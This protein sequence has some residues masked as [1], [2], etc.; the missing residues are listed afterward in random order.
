[1]ILSCSVAS[2]SNRFFRI[3]I[4]FW[5]LAAAAGALTCFAT[6]AGFC[7]PL[8][9]LFELT[10]HFRLQ[11]AVILGVLAV[12]FAV[13][14][15]ALMASLFAIGAA[16]NLFVIAPYLVSVNRM[17]P[18]ATDPLRILLLNV[19]TENSQY[20]RLLDFVRDETP[21]LV[22]LLEID[23][24]WLDALHP[25]RAEYPYSV[26]EPRDDNFGIALLSRMPFISAEMFYVGQIGV[27]SI[28]AHLF[29]HDP[30]E[31]SSNNQ[32][33]IAL[34]I[35]H[36][37]PPD[38]LEK[39][40]LRNH[41]LQVIGATIA[42]LEGPVILLGDLN[43]TPWSPH[44]RQ[45]L[46]QTG[47][48]DTARGRSLRGTWPAQVPPLRI[49]LDHCL[50]SPAFQVIERRVGPRLGSDPLP[51]LVTLQPS[52]AVGA[53]G[54]SPGDGLVSV[55]EHCVP[56]WSQDPVGRGAGGDSGRPRRSDQ[57][58]PGT[59]AGIRT[60]GPGLMDRG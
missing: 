59:A 12:A 26:A 37:L 23:D 5:G 38:S 3:R 10:C 31:L 15:T 46:Q 1:M 40:R 51:L 36:P 44:F 27:P 52:A 11:Y 18:P 39:F 24:R 53:G 21:D 20:Q 2:D 22:A 14:R 55:G 41:Q 33:P 50:V 54:E 49:P 19:R 17:I 32:D 34:F 7:A 8:G 56:G 9:W 35:T 29:L 6:L 4:E 60:A 45:L 57:A 48:R 25:L 43:V 42:E 30:G 58:G 47:L 28:R 16:I 13:R